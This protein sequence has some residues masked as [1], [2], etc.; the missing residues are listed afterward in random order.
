MLNE[1][2]VPEDATDYEIRLSIDVVEVGRTSNR[3]VPVVDEIAIVENQ[4]DD[5]AFVEC[6]LPSRFLDRE[7]ELLGDAYDRTPTL[8]RWARCRRL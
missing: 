7:A 6:V 4:H 1:L 5:T 2:G 8:R 3:D